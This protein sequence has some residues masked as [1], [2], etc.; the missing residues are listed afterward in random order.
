M[1][2]IK[3]NLN[4]F[5]WQ[6]QHRNAGVYR[7]CANSFYY[8]NKENC[9]NLKSEIIENLI[10][11]NDAQKLGYFEKI[12]YEID[13][14]NEGYS[15][16]E[17][18]EY[19]ENGYKNLL[20]KY[21]IDFQPIN[22]LC[23]SEMLKVRWLNIARELDDFLTFEYDNKEIRAME[24]ERRE[25]GSS[26]SWYADFE[27]IFYLSNS[28]TVIFFIE[29]IKKFIN[30]LSLKYKLIDFRQN[31]KINLEVEHRIKWNTSPYHFGFIINEFINKGFFKLESLPLHNGEVNYSAIARLF[32][33]II[34]FD[35]TDQNLIK[36]FNP[37]NEKLSETVKN[38]F[39]IPKIEDVQSKNSVSK[40][41]KNKIP[42]TPIK[43]KKRR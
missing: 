34:D 15:S 8:E 19:I 43:P 16:I 14:A 35:T 25:N 7:D 26:R 6:I 4:K 36:S 21:K 10:D 20:A 37:N 40:G 39:T 2:I 32:D 29:E 23:E 33:S 38:K 18:V 30:E 27:E 13:K 24:L 1:A 17:M 28:K 42:E 9:N 31:S 11:L 5:I 41:T 3:D 22:E 12:V